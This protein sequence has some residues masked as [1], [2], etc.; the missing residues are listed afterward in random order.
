VN[1]LVNRRYSFEA[2][3]TA[4]GAAAAR[5]GAL[6]VVLL[7]AN[8]GLL[9]ALT[10]LGFGLLPAKLITEAVLVTAS[11]RIQR[12]VVFATADHRPDVARPTAAPVSL[13]G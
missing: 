1:F 12:G 2:T 9:T 3:G 13:P 4:V 8:F 10:G 6:A 5:Y 11:Y 7:A